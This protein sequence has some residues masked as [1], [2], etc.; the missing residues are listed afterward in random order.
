MIKAAVRLL[1]LLT[2]VLILP[3]SV[4]AEEVSIGEFIETN[5][6]MISTNDF[7]K[8][9]NGQ[10]CAL[11]R[12]YAPAEKVGFE[13]SIVGD[14]QY[15]VNEYWVFLTSGTKTIKVLYYSQPS[16]MVDITKFIG[17]PVKSKKI[18]QMK[19]NIPENKADLSGLAMTP[20][21]QLLF[22]KQLRD[23]DDEIS[24]MKWFRMA[25]D[26]GNGEAMCLIGDYFQS[27]QKTNK[28]TVG[29]NI[30][31]KSDS[32]MYWYKRSA[33]TGFPEGL[34]KAAVNIEWWTNLADT[35]YVRKN[36]EKACNVGYGPA[37][38]YLGAYYESLLINYDVDDLDWNDMNI[39][40]LSP[41]HILSAKDYKENHN[42][43]DLDKAEYWYNE[44]LKY[45]KAN[46][47]YHLGNL[48]R[49]HK[50]SLSSDERNLKAFDYYR[51]AAEY[52]QLESLYAVYE[53]YKN[54]WGVKKNDKMS[55]SYLEKAIENGYYA[56]KLY[57]RLA[58]EFNKRNDL[59]SQEKAYALCKRVVTGTQLYEEKKSFPTTESD[60]FIAAG[61]MIDIEN[62]STSTRKDRF[63]IRG[64]CMTHGE[65]LELYINN[66]FNRVMNDGYFVLTDI[67]PTDSIKI[68][69]DKYGEYDISKIG[70]TRDFSFGYEKF[71]K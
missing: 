54:G 4:Q 15:K 5:E 56:P 46:C 7:R 33:D 9:A 28:S 22:G 36:L 32:I 12:V 62:R 58:E 10:L 51:Q 21:E 38:A 53:Y 65:M 40:R 49:Y 26:G 59:D 13:G 50:Y 17:G 47:L 30:Q 20:T 60:K 71:K 57:I 3:I 34:F 43:Y 35:T 55:L 19:L 29:K 31:V 6:I 18:Y 70:D 14:V 66:K 1:I 69:S 45:D 25:A 44:G 16:V 8:D 48:Y 67:Y 37:F 39:L 64:H 63:T 27:K 68:L 23:K 11:L 42:Q 2:L 52:H 41:K 24:A 61:I